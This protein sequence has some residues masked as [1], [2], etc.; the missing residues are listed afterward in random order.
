MRINWNLP[1]SL[2]RLLK[3]IIKSLTAVSSGFVDEGK[4]FGSSYVQMIPAVKV[5]VLAGEPTSTLRF[6]EIWHFFEQQLHYPLLFWM[7]IM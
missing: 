6:G 4:D 5:A 1:K 7:R 2:V 3:N